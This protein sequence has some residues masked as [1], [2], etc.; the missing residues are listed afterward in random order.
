[1]QPEALL[2]Q[3]P[4]EVGVAP[5]HGED[6]EVAHRLGRPPRLAGLAEVGQRALVELGRPRQVTPLPGQRAEHGP[7]PG[8]ALEVA[9]RRS[10]AAGTCSA[11]DAAVAASPRSHA[12]SARTRE[13]SASHHRSPVRSA[14]VSASSAH[15]SAAPGSSSR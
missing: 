15:T 4:P 1:M 11:N 8:R 9:H 2:G 7:G 5:Q 10:T 3:A 14:S 12:S 13:A 6:A